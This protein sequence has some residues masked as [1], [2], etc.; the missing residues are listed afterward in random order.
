MNKR[1]SILDG[2]V[3]RVISAIFFGTRMARADKNKESTLG[4]IA[5]KNTPLR[6]FSQYTQAIMDLGATVCALAS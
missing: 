1:A 6:N 3:K 5:D 4:K 2:N